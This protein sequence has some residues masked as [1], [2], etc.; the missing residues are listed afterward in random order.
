MK[1]EHQRQADQA[2][3]DING[4]WKDY[5]E[6]VSDQTGWSRTDL[7]LFNIYARLMSFSPPK[8]L[9]PEFMERY[10]RFMNRE[11]DQNQEDWKPT[12]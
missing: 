5:M 1:E 11:M 10:E 7:M 12:E 8:T 3:A 2:V 9:S 4:F 6:Y